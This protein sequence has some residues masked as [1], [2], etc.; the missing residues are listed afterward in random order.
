MIQN[1]VDINSIKAELDRLTGIKNNLTVAYQTYCATN[2]QYVQTVIVPQYKQVEVQIQNLQAMYNKAVQSAQFQ[3]HG[4]IGFGVPVGQDMFKRETQQSSFG[5][6]V[7]DDLVEDMSDEP[8]KRVFN[9]EFVNQLNAAGGIL[10][11]TEVDKLKREIEILRREN[12]EMK[13]KMLSDSERGNIVISSAGVDFIMDSNISSVFS[14]HE[15]C[16][17]ELLTHLIVNTEEGEYMDI[18]NKMIERYENI[19]SNVEVSGINFEDDKQSGG[20]RS[21]DSI[22]RGVSYAIS[23]IAKDNEE[24]FSTSDALKFSNFFKIVDSLDEDTL[25]RL[26]DD[27]IG[28]K[29]VYEK[30]F[31]ELHRLLRVYGGEDTGNGLSLSAQLMKYLEDRLIKVI[32]LFWNKLLNKGFDLVEG[33]FDFDTAEYLD[34]ELFTIDGELGLTMEEVEFIS[35]NL[36]AVINSEITNFKLTN[37]EKIEFTGIDPRQYINIERNEVLYCVYSKDLG[38]GNLVPDGQAD[39][40]G[41]VKSLLGKNVLEGKV[42][43]VTH[44]ALT[45]VI[46]KIFKD[47]EPKG[48]F[49]ISFCSHTGEYG[50]YRVYECIFGSTGT[51][52]YLVRI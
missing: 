2:P 7:V 1:R 12:R 44:P 45:A 22:I 38:S 37:P 4:N 36:E 23:T 21:L 28:N 35:K 14:R 40:H 52:Y 3:Q 25:N 50:T 8:L 26:N 27:V 47:E 39:T 24:V 31:K 48:T 29:F 11:E 46:E 43:E 49:T 16:N 15:A 42:N 33:E 10:P 9:E 30:S 6:D 20:K 41:I 5:G 32:N 13:S 51:G 19:L 18:V 34:R 17:G